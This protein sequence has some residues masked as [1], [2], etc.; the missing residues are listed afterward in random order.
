D[1][2]FSARHALDVLDESDAGGAKVR[3][4]T[5]ES[6]LHFPARTLLRAG[7]GR[8]RRPD[9]DEQ[10]GKGQFVGEFRHES[11]PFDKASIRSETRTPARLRRRA[12]QRKM[13]PGAARFLLDRLARRLTDV[14]TLQ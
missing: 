14:V 13:L 1:F 7:I 4:R 5:G 8:D 12:V 10:A 2:E 6:A 11:P 3:E 9:Q